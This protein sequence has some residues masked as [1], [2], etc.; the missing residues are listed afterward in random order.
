LAKKTSSKPRSSAATRTTA[1]TAKSG[2]STANRTRT[3][4]G[5][6]ASARETAKKHVGDVLGISR[7]RVSK[8]VPSGGGRPRGI[9]ITTAPRRMKRAK[10]VGGVRGRGR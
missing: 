10:V 4:A 9:E 8:S 1:A 5:R 2:A 6:A 7:A 3:A